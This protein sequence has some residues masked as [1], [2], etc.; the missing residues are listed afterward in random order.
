MM[1][2][3]NTAVVSRC[4]RHGATDGDPEFCANRVN[5]GWN[6]LAIVNLNVFDGMEHT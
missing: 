2:V 3:F 6:K 1:K 5:I 4:V